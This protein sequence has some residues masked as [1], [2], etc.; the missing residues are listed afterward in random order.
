MKSLYDIKMQNKN[1]NLDEE[2]WKIF[3]Q[4]EED[5]RQARIAVLLEEREEIIA[6]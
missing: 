5:K 6:K 1:L 4:H 3:L 2:A